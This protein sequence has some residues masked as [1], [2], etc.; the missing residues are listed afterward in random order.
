MAL[1]TPDLSGGSNVFFGFGANEQ[2]QIL[3]SLP[4]FS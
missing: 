2:Q 3:E 4:D 1:L